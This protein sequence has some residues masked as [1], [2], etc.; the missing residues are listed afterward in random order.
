MKR[1]AGIRTPLGAGMKL[2]L[3]FAWLRFCNFILNRLRKF[4]YKKNANPSRILVFRTGSLGD[5][6]CAIPAIAAIRKKYPA[7]QLHIVTNAGRTNLVTLEKLLDPDHYNGIIDYFGYGKKELFNL[8]KKN[9][10]DQV[11]YLPQTNSSLVRLIRDL[12]FFRFIGKSGFGWELS[13][14]HFFRRTQEK[15][16]SFDNEITRLSKML[17][18]HGVI[19]DEKKFPLNFQAADQ[20]FVDQYFANNRL[21]DKNRSIAVVVGA[22]RPQN[23]WPLNY[24]S[25]VIAHFHHSY[26]ILL[27]GG[28]EDK[29]LTGSFNGMENVFNCCGYFTPVQSALALKKCSLVIS[30]DTGPMHFGYVVGT[31]LIALFSSRDFPGKW[32]PPANPGNKVFRTAKVHCSICLS[33]NCRNNICMQAISPGQVIAE[34]E[35]L[36]YENTRHA[37]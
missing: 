19:V 18:K 29:E 33:E 6:L 24:F 20:Q 23:R 5:N 11:I 14:V 36:L 28:P 9:N 37:V 17:A 3:V 31:P 30:N 12:L 27:I 22:K 16:I 2:F 10:Y 25:Q 26:N 35:R 21:T 15:Y 8:L 32:F 13:T 1:I 34:A 7:A 4:F